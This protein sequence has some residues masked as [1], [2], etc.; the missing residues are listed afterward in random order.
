MTMPHSE[1]I[2]AN[3]NGVYMVAADDLA[4]IDNQAQ[5]LNLSRLQV[6]LH[7]CTNKAET[8]DRLVQGLRVPPGF[9]ANWDA[10]A[11]SLRDL[12]W[13]GDSDGYV[14]LL[15]HGQTLR[16]ASEATFDTLVDVL[17]QA[18]REWAAEGLPFHAFIALPESALDEV[19]A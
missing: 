8:M 17:D 13:L 10:L 14:M 2:R 7:D 3:D 9:G 11:D 16:D 15:A 12:S 18:A 1:L 5:D 19:D 6:D 4:A